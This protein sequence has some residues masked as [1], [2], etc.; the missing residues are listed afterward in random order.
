MRNESPAP[1]QRPFKNLRAHHPH[2]TIPSP[3]GQHGRAPPR[4]RAERA[5]ALCGEYS[6]TLRQVR[7]GT[8]HA[9][10]PPSPSATDVS[11]FRVRGFATRRRRT[12]G[13]PER[14]ERFRL[15]GRSA[16]AGTLRPANRP[17][18][19]IIN[20]YICLGYSQEHRNDGAHIKTISPG[21]P[22]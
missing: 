15:I 18:A 1:L 20:H 13:A 17:P 19:L 16:D 5:G 2:H 7:F 6:S 4:R 9:T 8:P 14:Q 10:R 3:H 11:R 12:Y 21:R 22:P